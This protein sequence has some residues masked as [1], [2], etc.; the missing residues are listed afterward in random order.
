MYV[1]TQCDGIA[2]GSPANGYRTWRTVPGPRQLPNAATGSGLPSGLI[3]CLLVTKDGTVYAGTAAG[4][5]A[6]GDKGRTWHF[7]RGADWKDKEAGLADP[8]APSSRPVTGTL[9]REDDVT[10][11]AEDGD[12]SLWVGYRQRGVELY[13]RDPRHQLIPDTTD[14]TKDNFIAALL[15]DGAALWV[16]RYGGGLTLRYGEP[17]LASPVLASLPARKMPVPPLPVPAAP[18]TLAQLNTMLKSV[19]A[20]APDKNELAPKVVA[21]EDDWRTEGDWLGRYG[22]YWASLNAICSPNNYT[23]GA[24]WQNV[25]YFSQVGP[26]HAEGDSLRYWVQWLYTQD[27]RVLELP[28]TYLDSRVKKGLTTPD[29]NRR[30]AEQDDHGEVYV[31]SAEGP[32]VYETLTVPAGLFFL[33]LYDVNYNGHQDSNRFRDYRVSVRAHAG[34]EFSDIST[35]NAQP[36]LAHGRIQNFWGGVWKRFLVRGPVTLIVKVDRNNSWNTMLPGVMLDL[37]DE[38]PPP[39]FGSVDQWE[40]AQANQEEQRQQAQ[41]RGRIALFQPA[42]TEQEAARRL[43]DILGKTQFMNSGWWS[44]DSR[45]FYAPLLRWYSQATGHTPK[46]RQAVF[47]KPLATCCYQMGQ[48]QQWEEEQKC[49]GLTPARDVEKSLRWDGVSDMGQGYQVITKQQFD[50][51]SDIALSEDEHKLTSLSSR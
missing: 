21:L 40:E 37:V 34:A 48:Y 16:G 6:S 15:P 33:S 32:D 5:A 49:I 31:Q 1:G 14:P 18:P 36:E 47:D 11:L 27:P 8:V 20:V 50:Q 7:R 23:W 12:R 35:F 39:Y 10:C 17:A 42:A 43:S 29:S 30:E 3:N 45:Q 26:H 22:R 25:S 46:E 13:Y 19:C 9:L 4:L 51:T 44:A 2:I 24:G 41:S 38:T 28:P